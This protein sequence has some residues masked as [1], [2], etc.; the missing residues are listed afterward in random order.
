MIATL[1]LA[2]AI[3]QPGGARP[4]RAGAE[5]SEQPGSARVAAPKKVHASATP[6]IRTATSAPSI[7][8]RCELCHV[9]ASWQ[10]IT[11]PH[12]KTGFPLRGGHART[13][14]SACHSGGFDVKLVKAC[15]SCHR[16][17]HGGELGQRCDGCHSEETWKNAV[18]A[19][20]HRR[21]NFPLEGRHAVI[22]CEE[23]HVDVRDRRFTRAALECAACHQQDVDRAALTSIDHAKAGFDTRCQKCHSPTRFDRARF[24]EHDACFPILQGEH[25]GIACRDC[26]STLANAIVTGMCATNTAACTSCHEH[27]CDRS[28]AEHDRIPGYQC[29]DRKCY[30]CHTRGEE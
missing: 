1:V 4:G 8:S 10:Q 5:P 28:D 24:A 6:R 13:S 29:R 21:T 14:C 9:T 23:C 22:P 3:A 19:D 11:F 16:D 17:V 30:E 18:T 7:E 26:H 20:S 12:E 25:K 2:L 27:S 15:A